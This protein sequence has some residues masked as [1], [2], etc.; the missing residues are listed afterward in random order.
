MVYYVPAYTK[1]NLD[2]RATLASAMR[3]NEKDKEERRTDVCTR[4]S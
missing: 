4:H 2:I 1:A 3:A